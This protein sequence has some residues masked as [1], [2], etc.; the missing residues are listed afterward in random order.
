MTAVAVQ[1]RR[2]AR[3]RRYLGGLAQGV[4]AVTSKE[5]RGRMR[6]RRAFVVLTVYLMLLG[7][8]TYGLFLYEKQT[9]ANT[10]G[11]VGVDPNFGMG[12]DGAQNLAAT[13]GH[14]LFTGLLL[15]ETLLVLVLAPAFTSGAL[16]L[17]R[18]KQTIDLL[19][20]TPLSSLAVVIG[21]LFSALVYVLLLIVASIPIASLVF[22]FGGVGPE[23][24]VRAYL[25]LFALAFG[26]GAVGLFISA[27]VKRTQVATVATYVVVLSLAL[28][29]FMVWAF[30]RAVTP[31]RAA[32]GFSVTQE[33]KRPPEALLW[34]NPF[35]AG[36]DLI[37]G[38]SPSG[39]HETCVFISAVTGR[40]YF[41]T[42]TGGGSRVPP[43]C[44]QKGD[45]M[46]C[47]DH[48][49]PGPLPVPV[50]P[51]EVDGGG[52]LVPPKGGGDGGLLRRFE[53]RL[54]NVCPA[55]AACPAVGVEVDKPQVQPTVAEPSTF[56]F[57]RD[58]YWPRS[59]AAFLVT[60][61][62]LTLLSTQ[63]VAPTRRLRLPRRRWRGPKGPTSIEVRPV[64]NENTDT[65]PSTEVPA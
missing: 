57:P 56:G 49:A 3:P 22:T 63:L 62:V 33:Q 31:A 23:D 64:R 8:F 5:L 12:S 34:L 54:A 35:A 10:G 52:E 55:D 46:V 2:L 19:V 59:A 20:T 30:W 65:P 28:G 21:K 37:C 9:T 51:V 48:A 26:M 16:S 14:T 45:V 25:F 17:E 18:E 40:T 32:T 11:F 38:T 36:A 4:V 44:F 29:T 60:G 6:G 15:L 27:L 41:G 42:P 58:T 53:E 39:Y 1:R 43:N 7:L 50:P 24:L 13:I 47:E 61:V